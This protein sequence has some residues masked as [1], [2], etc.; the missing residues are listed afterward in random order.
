MP[1]LTLEVKDTILSELLELLAP[2]M[3]CLRR[4]AP[5]PSHFKRFYKLGIE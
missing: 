5:C 1:C 3:A 2:G 4:M